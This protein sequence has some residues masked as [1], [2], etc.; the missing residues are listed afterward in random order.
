MPGGYAW[1]FPKDDHV[2]VGVGGYLDEGPH[3]RAHLASI[4]RSYGID[5]GDLTV[6]EVCERYL[7]HREEE[8]GEKWRP[9]KLGNR[10]PYALDVEADTIFIEE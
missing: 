5:V 7:R 9:K 10:E 4:C 6:S 8:L 1:A 2:N 3:L